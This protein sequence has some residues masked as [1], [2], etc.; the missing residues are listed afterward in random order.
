M[1]ETILPVPGAEHP[2]EAGPGALPVSAHQM[3][4]SIGRGVMVLSAEYL[5]AAALRHGSG[6]LWSMARVVGA[7]HLVR[8]H[9]IIYNNI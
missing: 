8:A 5:V 4:S 1:A 3:M 9:V 2:V 7:V 6:A